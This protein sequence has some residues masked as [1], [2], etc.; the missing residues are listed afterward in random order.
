M[1]LKDAF[2]QFV[3]DDPEVELI[4]A[5]AIKAD[6]AL[7]RVYLEGCCYPGGCR[8]W[9][10]AFHRGQLAGGRAQEGPIGYL[11]DPPRKD[12]QRAADV[13]IARYESLLTLLRRGKLEGIGDPTRSRGSEVIL[14]SIWSHSAYFFD[15]ARGDLL[16]TNGS[17][18]S[19]NP[20]SI[21]WRAVTLR[22]PMPANLFHV[23]PRISDQM[24]SSTMQSQP[25]AQSKAIRRVETKTTSQN[26]CRDWLIQIIEKS[27]NKRTKSIEQLW[28]EAKEKWPDS[29]SERSFR[30]AREQAIGKV[31]ASAWAAAGAPKKS[32]QK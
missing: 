22:R 14:R 5:R 24:L 3:L 15:A 13:L 2:W 17:A 16:Q 18:D 11:S 21:R 19:S 32:I 29:L 12:V 6:P 9:P 1:S 25:Q 30:A 7:K 31:G 27:P 20:F 4:G 10:L 23:K 26:A 28:K 8:E